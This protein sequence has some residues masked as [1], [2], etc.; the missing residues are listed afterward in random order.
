VNSF[1]ESAGFFKVGSDL[2]EMLRADGFDPINASLKGWLEE[3]TRSGSGDDCTLGLI[4]R[5]DALMKVAA[6]PAAEVSQ[7]EESPPSPPAAEG[8]NAA[9]QP[10]EPAAAA[11]TSAEQGPTTTRDEQSA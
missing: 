9:T 1:S 4:V 11:S 6:S 3:A 5:M 8:A 10:A 2:L 7:A